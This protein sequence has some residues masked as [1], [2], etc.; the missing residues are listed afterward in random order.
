MLCDVR[1]S[2]N[3]GAKRLLGG[4]SLGRKTETRE[5]ATL[6]H[7]VAKALLPC[8]CAERR[9][10]MRER[11]RHTQH[12]RRRIEHP[13]HRVVVLLDVVACEGLDDHPDAVLRDRLTR[14]AC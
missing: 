10:S 7:D 14:P 13:T 12:R 11:M 5:T 4:G 3:L 6:H 8:L 2:W 1:A 9:P